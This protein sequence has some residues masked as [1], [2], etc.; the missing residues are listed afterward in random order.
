MDAIPE[1]VPENDN[2]LVDENDKESFRICVELTLKREQNHKLEVS[3]RN[4]NIAKN[5]NFTPEERTRKMFNYFYEI[6]NIK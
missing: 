4:K 3:K 5:K 2:F 6:L 1:L